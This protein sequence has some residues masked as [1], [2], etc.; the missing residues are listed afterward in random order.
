VFLES[1]DGLGGVDGFDSIL[2]EP[3]QYG[4]DGVT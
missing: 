3:V 2:I 1:G 4:F